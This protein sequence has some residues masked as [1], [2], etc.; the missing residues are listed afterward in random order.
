MPG[1]IFLDAKEDVTVCPKYTL[2]GLDIDTT[3]KRLID[4]VIIFI[5]LINRLFYRW[6]LFYPNSPTDCPVGGVHTQQAVCSVCDPVHEPE[7]GSEEAAPGPG[8][9]HGLFQDAEEHED[10]QGDEDQNGIRHPARLS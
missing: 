10:A 2:V 6:N 1:E 9:H 3:G 7:S 4:E 5:F 8:H